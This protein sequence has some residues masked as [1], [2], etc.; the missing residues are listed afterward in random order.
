VEERERACDEELIELGY[1]PAGDIT[2][3]SPFADR[4]IRSSRLDLQNSNSS[5]SV[6]SNTPAGSRIPCSDSRSGI[7]TSMAN[8]IAVVPFVL[9]GRS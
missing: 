1:P 8:M 7:L 6:N 5:S 2:I 3:M 9:T 4:S